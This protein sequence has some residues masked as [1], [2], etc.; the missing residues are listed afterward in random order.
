[1]GGNQMALTPRAM[2]RITMLMRDS[3]P[4]KTDKLF[5][6]SGSSVCRFAHAVPLVR[7]WLRLWLV[8]SDSGYRIARGFGSQIIAAHPERRLAVAITSDPNGR[9]RSQGYFGV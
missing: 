8:L 6:A 7:A 2:L 4:S 3:A 1:M 5:R 9:A